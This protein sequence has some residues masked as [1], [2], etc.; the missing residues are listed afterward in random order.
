[1]CDL[2]LI[3]ILKALFL[4]LYFVDAYSNESA[5]IMSDEELP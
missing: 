4:M 3:F 1:M 2:I 5:S